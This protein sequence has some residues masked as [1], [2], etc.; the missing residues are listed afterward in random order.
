MDGTMSVNKI[1]F[2]AKQKGN[3]VIA[4]ILISHPMETGLRKS[5][6]TGDLIPAHYIQELILEKEGSPLMD[7]LWGRSVSENPYLSFKLKGKK[8]ESLKVTWYDSKGQ[9]GSVVTIIQ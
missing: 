5:P 2:K 3:T 6:V 9:S 1:R 4:K 8:G 7:C